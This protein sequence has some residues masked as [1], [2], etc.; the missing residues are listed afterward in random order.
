[1]TLV[2]GEQAVLA[3][4]A[5]VAGVG[6]GALVARLTLPDVLLASDGSPPV[7]TVLVQLPWGYVAAAIG[8]LFAVLFVSSALAVLAARRARIGSI[9]RWGRRGEPGACGQAPGGR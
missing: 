1:M 5:T 7:P 2:G 8:A 3:A 9:L 6:L 4:F